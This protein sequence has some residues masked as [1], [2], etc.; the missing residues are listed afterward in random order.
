MCLLDDHIQQIRI[1]EVPKKACSLILGGSLLGGEMFE[2]IVSKAD[3]LFTRVFGRSLGRANSNSLRSGKS[4]RTAN[5]LLVILLAI[6]GLATF[7]GVSAFYG[8]EDLGAFLFS[9]ITPC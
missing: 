7:N 8:L 6:S 4:H 2:T 9:R 1:V 3:H 5:V